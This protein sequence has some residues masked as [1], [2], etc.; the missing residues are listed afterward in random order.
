LHPFKAVYQCEKRFRT[1][2]PPLLEGNERRPT[3]P[4]FLNG[5]GG[6]LKQTGFRVKKSVALVEG[7]G[8]IILAAR[9]A[10]RLPFTFRGDKRQSLGDMQN[11]GERLT[12]A[13]VATID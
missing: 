11:T 12:A 2:R 5:Q 4:D 9:M 10:K 1:N 3:T 7:V 8:T 13:N 6:T